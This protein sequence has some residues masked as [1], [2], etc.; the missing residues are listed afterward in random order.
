[1]LGTH[2]GNDYI[3]KYN[4]NN[5]RGD[6][7]FISK[8]IRGKE[9]VLLINNDMVGDN[10]IDQIKPFSWLE[11]TISKIIR[12]TKKK[13]IIRLHPNQPKIPE[14]LIK[15]I[16]Y[17]TNNSI[18][19][20]KNKHIGDDLKEA[21]LAVMY[22]SGSCVEC[23]LNGIPVISTDPKSFCYELLPKN[24]D[25]FNNFDMIN[26]PHI[27]SFLSAISNTHFTVGEIISGKFWKVLKGL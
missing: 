2:L 13:I 19:V 27:D 18:E 10:T 23:L 8:N 14:D 20:S 22:S 3:K 7:N 26:L 12:R 4:N 15:K 6:F 5:V 16:R 17:Q 9:H 24:I 11:D 1:M 21:S 25:Q